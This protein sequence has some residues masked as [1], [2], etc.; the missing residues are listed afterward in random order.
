MVGGSGDTTS[1]WPQRPSKGT[2]HVHKHANIAQV[3]PPWEECAVPELQA[4][5]EIY[6]GGFSVV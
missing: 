4:R 3:L 5:L 2:C 1:G 6:N